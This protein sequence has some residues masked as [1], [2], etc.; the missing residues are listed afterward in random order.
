MVLRLSSLF[1]SYGSDRGWIAL[2]FLASL[3]SVLVCVPLG[4]IFIRSNTA[5]ASINL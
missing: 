3:D 1:S 2:L 5:E 4:H